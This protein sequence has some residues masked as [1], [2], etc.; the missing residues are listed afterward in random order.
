MFMTIIIHIILKK[1]G[2]LPHIAL[3]DSPG[4]LNAPRYYYGLIWSVGTIQ[5][6]SHTSIW[7][8]YDD[9]ILRGGNGG[10]K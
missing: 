3:S 10:K 9:T 1:R 2:L 4:D 8:V 6:I 7:G 5:I